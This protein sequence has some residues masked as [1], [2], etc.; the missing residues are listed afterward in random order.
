VAF[1]WTNRPTIPATVDRSQP[2]TITW[3]NGFPGALVQ[4]EGQ[5][6]VSLGVGANFTCWADPT[7]GTF[8]VPAAILQAVPP[9]Y[10]DEGNAQGSLNVYQM[11]TGPT[12]TAPGLD[13]GTS[14]FADGQGEGAITYK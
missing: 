12:F 2:L 9:T 4:I 6:Q 8:A 11:I 14:T 5:S 3:T 1:Q 10:S 13:M 7:A